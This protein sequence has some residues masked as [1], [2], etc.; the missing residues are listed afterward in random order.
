VPTAGIAGSMSSGSGDLLQGN[1]SALVIHAAADDYTSDPAGNS[2]DRITC[3][4][5]ER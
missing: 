3:G 5:I 2:V 4:V 1:G